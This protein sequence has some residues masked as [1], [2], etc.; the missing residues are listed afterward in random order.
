MQPV[1]ADRFLVANLVLKTDV[2]VIAAF[3]H[4]LGGLSETRLVT[5]DRR[6]AEET[7]QEGHKGDYEQYDQRTR[8]R[9]DGKIDDRLGAARGSPLAPL[10]GRDRHLPCPAQRRF[11]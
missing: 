3:D 2:D 6:N 7:G 9:A 11:S 5:I 1:N 10:I 4:L 8:V